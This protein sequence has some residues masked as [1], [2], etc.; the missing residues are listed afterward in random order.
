MTAYRFCRTDDMGRLVDAWE[1]C[2]GPEEAQAPAL[3]L[4]SFKRLVRDLDLWCSSC[5]LALEGERPIG[6]L[7]GAKREAATLVWGLRVHPDHRRCGHGRHL[8]TSLGQKLAILG[9]PRLVAEVPAERDAAL[10]L[11]EAC[12]WEREER[13]IDWRRRGSGALS[14]AP[15]VA[16]AP[17]GPVTLDEARAGGLLDASVRCWRRDPEALRRRE[18]APQGL[19]FFSPERLEACVLAAPG[20]GPDGWELL[21]V[22]RAD[23]EVGRL[24][25]GIVLSELSRRGGGASLVLPGVAPGEI[26]PAQLAEAGFE[27]EGESLLLATTARAA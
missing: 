23:G 12:R 1:R 5:M 7:L 19:G 26:D 20:P 21:A 15:P 9:P 16:D 13:L 27:P 2:R 3:D 17:L 6:V 24:G 8:L 18:P 25:L 22:G 10:G 14:A 11:F 4:P